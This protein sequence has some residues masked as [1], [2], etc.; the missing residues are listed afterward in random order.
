L[1]KEA[2]LAMV[3]GVWCLQLEEDVAAIVIARMAEKNL[4][5]PALKR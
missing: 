4:E 1:S 5:L 2:R 3:V